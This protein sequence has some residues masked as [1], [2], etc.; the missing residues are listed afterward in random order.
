MMYRWK[1]TFS[2]PSRLKTTVLNYLNFFREYIA[3]TDEISLE[4]EYHTLF[5][6]EMLN[7]QTRLELTFVMADEHSQTRVMERL[8]DYMNNIFRDPTHDFAPELYIKKSQYETELL[9]VL[10]RRAL[11]DIRTDIRFHHNLLP[12]DERVSLV[13][14]LALLTMQTDI[15]GTPFTSLPEG[16]AESI[17]QQ[18]QNLRF[19]SE[20]EELSPALQKAL[21]TEFSTTNTAPHL[22]LPIRSASDYIQELALQAHPEG[23]W[24]RETYRSEEE[25]EHLP[26]RYA[27]RRAFSTA[28]Y[29]LLEQGQFSALH[30]I[31]SDEVW[32]FYDGTPLTITCI[33][34]NGALSE[35]HL[36]RNSSNG[37]VLQAVVPRGWW[38]G[39]HISNEVAQ[40]ASVYA[41]VGCTVA[42]GFDF[43]DFEM[44]PRTTLV[45]M[46]PQHRSVIERLTK[47]DNV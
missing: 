41:L 20:K 43:A 3:A 23:G 5:D 29:F 38:F 21:H 25:Y 12:N 45:K 14:A 46:F 35:I 31:Q 18:I 16:S 9:L 39:S 22:M 40:D 24:F 4:V 42:P 19:P 13:H 26:R 34:P 33:T 6:G 28:I 37:E 32:H 1:R 7:G 2:L 15:A 30:R 47:A 11:A 8:R 44:P 10:Y 36:G 27:G 17:E